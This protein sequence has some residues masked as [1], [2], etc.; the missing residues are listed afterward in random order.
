LIRYLKPTF[1]FFR[2]LSIDIVAGALAVSFYFSSLLNIVL[3]KIY[4]PALAISVWLIYISDHMADSLIL[5]KPELSRVLSFFLKRR[6]ILILMTTFLAIILSML[7]IMAP[8]SMVFFGAIGGIF[9]LAYLIINQAQNKYNILIIPREL[10]ISLFYVYGTCGYPVFLAGK[11]SVI[12]V[13]FAI[14]IFFLTLTN[15]LI[16][17]CFEHSKDRIEGVKSVAVIISERF[18]YVSG[19]LCSSAAV[20]LFSVGL[21]SGIKSYYF[22]TT[23]LVMSLILLSILLFRQFYRQKQ[24][25]GIIADLVFLIP[26]T[27]SIFF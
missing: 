22:S 5:N 20:L 17:S 7:L 26:W 3:P 2:I 16:Y 27:I 4:W 1:I 19:I 23:G 18:A 8:R 14:G 10:I 15:V 11:L 9:V 21:V 6:L 13:L 12:D 25:Y 24:L